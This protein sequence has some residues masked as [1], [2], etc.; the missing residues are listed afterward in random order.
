MQL[1][2]FLKLPAKHT[3]VELVELVELLKPPS[4]TQLVKLLKLVELLK[5]FQP[6]THC[7]TG[8]SYGTG[9]NF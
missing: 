6:E 5:I 3:P 4:H 8:G 1:V 9:G 7:G 2:E